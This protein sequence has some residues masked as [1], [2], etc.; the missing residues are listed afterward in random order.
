[1]KSKP[2]PFRRM[3]KICHSIP[4]DCKNSVIGERIHFNGLLCEYRVYL[5]MNGKPLTRHGPPHR[6]YGHVVGRTNKVKHNL[7]PN[8][9]YSVLG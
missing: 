7:L 3:V 9:D 1:M 4:L 2:I 6:L 5:S 8:L